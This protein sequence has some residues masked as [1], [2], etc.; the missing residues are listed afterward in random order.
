MFSIP[1]MIA[2]GVTFAYAAVLMAAAGGGGFVRGSLVPERLSVFGDGSEPQ[3]R[4]LVAKDSKKTAAPPSTRCTAGLFTGTW[5]YP[6]C[7]AATIEFTIG[8]TGHDDT[9]CSFQE[10]IVDFTGEQEIKTCPI[11]GLFQDETGSNV[12]YNASNGRCEIDY[13]HFTEDL[14][15]LYPQ[16]GMKAYINMNEEDGRDPPAT[17]HLLFSEDGGET[18]YNKDTQR[19][20][21]RISSD[22]RRDLMEEQEEHSET[23]SSSWSS[24]VTTAS[25]E[26]QRRRLCSSI[27]GVPECTLACKGEKFDEIK[28]KRLGRECCAVE[29][30]SAICILNSNSST[31][32]C[33]DNVRCHIDMRCDDNETW[34]GNKCRVKPGIPECALACQEEKDE[35]KNKGRECC[36]DKGQSRTCILNSNS[37]TCK[38]NRD[39][40]KCYIDMRCDDKNEECEAP[41]CSLACKMERKLN[42]QKKASRECC[43]GLGEFGKCILNSKTSV[44]NCSNDVRCYVDM[45]C[46]DNSTWRE[47]KKECRLKP[48]QVCN[49]ID[50]CTEGYHC[51]GWES[52]ADPR[53]FCVKSGAGS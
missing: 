52:C 21:T 46:D 32:N 10:T 50:E 16:L 29:G 33:S 51:L 39:K 35:Q 27:E 26:L 8:C 20:A 31:C 22:T 4:V 34:Q 41:E 43:K 2:H 17:M 7:D 13:F 40:G 18:F 37:S 42:T 44:C 25:T 53:S 5:T 3:P 38:C 24:S 19:V 14:C 1:A 45:R 28:K 23:S 48:Y 15:G 36:K 47:D 9:T 11:G 12:A 49:D 30:Q 6:N